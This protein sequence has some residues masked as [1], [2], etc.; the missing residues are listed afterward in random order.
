MKHVP[1]KLSSLLLTCM[2][3]TFSIL[4][5]LQAPSVTTE[6]ATANY[7]IP[8]SYRSLTFY[9][10]PQDL[11][12]TF[13]TIPIYRQGS[14]R[15]PKA[16]AIKSLKSTNPAVARPYIDKNG[17]LRIY[18]FKTTGK[19]TV[20]FKIGKQTLK[21]NIT[22]KNYTNPFRTFKIGKLNFTSRF[23]STTE[24][25]YFHTSSLK[26]Q[27]VTI[28]AAKG[29]KIVSIDIKYGASSYVVNTCS[30]TS[31]TNKKMSFNGTAD[32]IIFRMYH[33]KNNAYLNVVWN[34][35]KE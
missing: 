34:G 10:V 17:N 11:P 21:S 19:A 33:P 28:K 20:S 35:K 27:K 26:N 31:F 23:H 2:I 24:C 14:K 3:L 22:V 1:N 12:A 6:A 8:T 15:G 13:A 5:P 30:K 4:S 16:S 29:W 9:A 25:N 7:Y 18:F 32:H